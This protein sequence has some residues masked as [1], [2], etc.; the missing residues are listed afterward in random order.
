M[1]L[2]V[3]L[4][5]CALCAR[6][7][8][9]RALCIAAASLACFGPDRWMCHYRC[10]SLQQLNVTCLCGGAGLFCSGSFY[11]PLPV[12]KPAQFELRRVCH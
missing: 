3:F 12:R 8:L 9:D 11:A 1:K 5:G 7:C 2:P 6:P 4:K 10:A